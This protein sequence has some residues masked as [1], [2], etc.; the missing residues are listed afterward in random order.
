[1][2]QI[3]IYFWCNSGEEIIRKVNYRVITQRGNI[4]EVVEV[5]KPTDLPI[6]VD[7]FEADLRWQFKQWTRLEIKQIHYV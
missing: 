7:D 6:D 2:E 3:T 5:E 4:A 1:M